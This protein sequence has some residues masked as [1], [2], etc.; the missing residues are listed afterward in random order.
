[1]NR[2][3]DELREL[4]HTD[5]GKTSS[6][7]PVL[8][9]REIYAEIRSMYKEMAEEIV[10]FT[11]RMPDDNEETFAGRPLPNPEGLIPVERR[12]FIRSLCALFGKRPASPC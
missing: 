2:K 10:Y 7:A 5:Q 1:M 11:E 12:M 4:K 9:T 6:S 3:R 8:S